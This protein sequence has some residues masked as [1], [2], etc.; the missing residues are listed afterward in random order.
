MSRGGTSSCRCR[1]PR[2]VQKLLAAAGHGSRRQIEQW[3]RAGRVTVDG[4]VVEL[5]ERADRERRY[6]PRWPAR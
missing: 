3:I 6:P 4:H 2:A 1:G 5:G